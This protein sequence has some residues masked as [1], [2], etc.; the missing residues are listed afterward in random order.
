MDHKE[1]KIVLK[2][3]ILIIILVSICV[4][5]VTVVNSRQATIPRGW[6]YDE[7]LSEQ[8]KIENNPSFNVVVYRE[9]F[10][11]KCY[12][13]AIQ[14]FGLKPEGFTLLEKGVVYENET[15]EFY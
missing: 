8:Y 9:T 5:I 2:I 10:C 6:H 11:S 4:I 7:N 3:F 15:M 13:I 12:P 14:V 1:A